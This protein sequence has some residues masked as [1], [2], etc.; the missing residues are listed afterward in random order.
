M[1]KTEADKELVSAFQEYLDSVKAQIEAKK[2][3][4]NRAGRRLEA[5]NARRKG[6]R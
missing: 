2:P 6:K 5:K 4:L 1:E 3:Q